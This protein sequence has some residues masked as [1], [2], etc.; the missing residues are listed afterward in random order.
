MLAVGPDGSLV[1]LLIAAPVYQREWILSDW[2]AAIER[3]TVPLSDIGFAFL[4]SPDDDPTLS[5]LIRFAETHPELRCFDIITQEGPHASHP[6]GRR[7][8]H[9]TR[10]EHMT[11]MRNTLLGRAV[12]HAPDKYFSL[13][14]DILLEREDTI[15]QLVEFTDRDGVDAAAPLCYMTPDSIYFPSTMSWHN[16]IGQRACRRSDYPLG[17]RFSTDIIMAA[18]M[19]TPPVYETVRYQYHHQGEDLGWSANLALRKFQAWA[20]FDLYCPHIMS[21]GMLEEY[22]KAGDGRSQIDHSAQDGEGR[23]VSILDFGR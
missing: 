18:K 14:T 23:T 1:F 8:W 16:G 11:Q 15:Q 6:E 17:S 4:V 20:A 10:Y 21:R 19:M 2:F 12:C 9:A 7:S 3:Q 5:C 13:D 22:R